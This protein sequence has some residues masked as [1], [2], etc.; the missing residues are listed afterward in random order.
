MKKGSIKQAALVMAV[1]GLLLFRASVASAGGQ[2]TL[3]PLIHHI[4]RAVFPPFHQNLPIRS[5][6]REII[7][8]A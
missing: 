4:S 1:I 2:P 3:S 8:D 7:L 6:R 5:R